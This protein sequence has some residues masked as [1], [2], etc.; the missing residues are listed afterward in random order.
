MPH[1]LPT[2]AN[3]TIIEETEDYYP[4]FYPAFA[5]SAQSAEVL[6]NA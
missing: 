5:W 4:V 3:E 6:Q 2:L 1:I